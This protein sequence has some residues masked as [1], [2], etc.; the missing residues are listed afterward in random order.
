MKKG[1]ITKACSMVCALTIGVLTGCQPDEFGS[2]N[3]LDAAPVTASFTVTKV[4]GKVNT[5]VLKSN[6]EG[7]VGVKWDQGDGAFAFGPTID[8]VV[9][10]DA[11]TYTVALTTIGKSGVTATSAPQDIVV[12]TS[13]PV[14]GNLVIGGKMNEE[15]V[16]AWTKLTIGGGNVNFNFVDGKLVASGGDWGHNAIYQAIEVIGGKKYKLDL[17]VSGSGATDVWFEVYLGTQEPS[18]N[19]DYSNGGIQLGI[20]TWTGCGKTPFNGKLSSIAC[21]GS[22]MGTG[23]TITFAESG[24]IYLLIK[25]GGANLGASGISIDNVEL[26]GAK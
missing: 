19:N 16:D 21:V 11:G 14:A 24:T 17:S 7:V 20:N 10:P 26:R 2:G 5:Y 13:D 22:L 1:N 18:Q 25:T 23:K 12:A 8:T 4:E 3:G 15:D 9:Y 6:T